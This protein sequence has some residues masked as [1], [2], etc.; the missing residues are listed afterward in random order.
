MHASCTSTIL[1]LLSACTHECVQ[2]MQVKASY[3]NICRTN[4][5]T[6]LSYSSL[7]LFLSKCVQSLAF[8]VHITLLVLPDLPNIE[9]QCLQV[10][11]KYTR[12]QILCMHR[13][14]WRKD[15]TAFQKK[16]ATF[17]RLLGVS[18]RCVSYQGH[19]SAC[20][21]IHFN[22]SEATPDTWLCFDTAVVAFTSQTL[23]RVVKALPA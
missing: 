12:M 8:H 10:E 6:L 9:A 19:S 21:G 20:N 3:T 16:P 13:Q 22:Y 7:S 17:A 15:L 18:H 1:R 5:L 14:R 2:V 23:Q 4:M 11:E